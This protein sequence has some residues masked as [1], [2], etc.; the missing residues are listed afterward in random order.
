MN[1]YIPVILMLLLGLCA[2]SACSQKPPA[3]ELEEIRKTGILRVGVL[4][5]NFPEDNFR[6]G[7]EITGF[8]TGLFEEVAKR[9]GVRVK[10]I[11][12]PQQGLIS[13]VGSSELDTAAVPFDST[14]L[15]DQEVDF[16]DPYFVLSS[17][18]GESA[19]DQDKEQAKSFQVYVILPGGEKELRAKLNEVI[20]GMVE[21]GYIHRLAQKYNLNARIEFLN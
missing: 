17:P 10:F 1:R 13:A 3:N 15:T 11:E 21:E 12:L 4:T 14:R 18:P 8:F 6:G 16:A 20:G 9:M 5:E 2:A 7:G 19:E